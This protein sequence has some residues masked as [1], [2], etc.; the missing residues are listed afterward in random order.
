MNDKEKREVIQWN[1]GEEESAGNQEIEEEE[2]KAAMKK[3]KKGK[4][5]GID[6]IS[7][8]MLKHMRTSGLEFLTKLCNRCLSEGIT[9]KEW[10]TGFIIPLFK[11][12]DKTQCTNYRGITLMSV[13]SKVYKRV[14]EQRLTE[15]TS[16]NTEASQSTFKKGRT[17]QD[18]I[19][20]IKQLE[21]RLK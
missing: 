20:N 10:K 8:E 1:E 3:L 7:V 17:V 13:P 2:V 21:K 14:L 16:Q 12:R 19:F 4:S 15:E 18:H 9:P 11:K 5:T 6:Q